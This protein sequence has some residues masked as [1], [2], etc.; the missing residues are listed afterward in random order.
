MGSYAKY[1]LERIEYY[2]ERG[3]DFECC[4]T[5]D[6]AGLLDVLGV[7]DG[8]RCD[9]ENGSIADVVEKEEKADIWD[10]LDDDEPVSVTNTGGNWLQ[11]MFADENDEED[12]G[13][14]WKSEQM[15]CAVNKTEETVN[16]SSLG[17]DILAEISGSAEEKL[18][19][20]ETVTEAEDSDYGYNF[21]EIDDEEIPYGVVKSVNMGES[22]RPLLSGLIQSSCAPLDNREIEEKVADFIVGLS[23]W[24]FSLGKR[25]ILG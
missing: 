14:F 5:E 19:G 15:V 1:R 9:I 4:R 23:K 2:R 10:S 12:N 22:D 13:E 11:D 21:G 6:E 8:A 18:S 16:Y 17:A 20:T 24:L 25:K 7:L 3:F